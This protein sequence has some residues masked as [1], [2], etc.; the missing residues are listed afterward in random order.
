MRIV[1]PKGT[2]YLNTAQYR[3]VDPVSMTVFEPGEATKATATD[4][5]GT[6]PCMTQ[7]PDPTAPTQEKPTS[8]KK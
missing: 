2:W 7:V 3:M 5:L 8:V 6:Q 4:W 1:D